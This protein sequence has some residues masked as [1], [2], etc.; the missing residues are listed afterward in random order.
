M[1]TTKNSTA[2]Q[3]KCPNC[4]GYVTFDSSSQ[5]MT[6]PYCDS[7]FD[8]TTLNDYTKHIETKE[9]TPKWEDYKQEDWNV[10]EADQLKYY[11]C[12]SCGGQ[13]ITDSVTAATKCPYCDNPVVLMDQLEGS[14]R[15]DLVIP[16]QL[17]RE[18]AINSLS[19]FLKGKKLLPRCF[20][21]DN[22]IEEVQGLYVPFWLYDCTSAG[23][24]MFKA[25]RSNTWSDRNYIYTKTKYYAAHRKGTMGFEK[26]PADGSIKMDDTMMESIEPF[27][28][29]KAVPF[30]TGFLSGYLA[31][32]YDVT[33]LDNEQRINTRITNSVTNQLQGTVTGYNTVH[34]DHKN[35]RIEQG[36]IQYALL[37]VWIL[38]TRYKDE[39]YTFAMNGQTGKFVGKLP[40]DRTKCITY[41]MKS[42][43][44][45]S[46]VG[47]L[48]AWF[49]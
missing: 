32:K 4:G 23:D 25:T 41:F 13:I 35:I 44:A 46:V 38:N 17:D 1:E 8:A 48:F 45:C 19:N 24:V 31:S 3:F 18:K 34:V 39:L 27:D 22:H 5:E 20:K 37:P 6:C 16:F 42:M 26:V 49:F 10:E 21:T 11:Q 40:I 15:P 30:N 29:T 43:V 9:E 12:K 36:T 7:T 47:T 28:Y 14:Y 33:C 2:D